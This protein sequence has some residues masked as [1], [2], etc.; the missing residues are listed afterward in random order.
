MVWTETGRRFSL[1]KK[2]WERYLCRIR[3]AIPRQSLSLRRRYCRIG[4][5]THLEEVAVALLSST[6]P[7]G[8]SPGPGRFEYGFASIRERG[9]PYSSTVLI[10]K[11]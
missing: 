4:E 3:S 5:I 6:T 7:W 8:R 10:P 2:D 1:T 9:L 11:W